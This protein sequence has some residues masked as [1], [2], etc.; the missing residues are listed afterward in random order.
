[1]RTHV[2]PCH[3]FFDFLFYCRYEIFRVDIVIWVRFGEC[4]KIIDRYEDHL[5]IWRILIILLGPYRM[6]SGLPLLRPS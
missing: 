5:R 1:M 2:P 4:I 6:P 3:D